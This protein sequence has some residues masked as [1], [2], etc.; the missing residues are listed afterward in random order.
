MT[1]HDISQQNWDS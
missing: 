1:Y